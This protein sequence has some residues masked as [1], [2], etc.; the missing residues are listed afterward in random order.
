VLASRALAKETLTLDVNGS[1]VKTALYR[2]YKAA[3]V[4]GQPVKITNTATRRC[5]RWSRFGFADHAGAGCIE[6]LQDRAQL[7]HA[8]RQAGRCLEG[9]TERPLCCGAEDHGSQTG[10]RSHHGIG[11]S[12]GRPRDR[13]SHLVSSG[14]TGTLD[15]IEDG[16]EPENTEFRDDALRRPSIAPATT[17]VFTVAMW[18]ARIARQICAARRP[19]SGHVQSLSLWPHRHRLGRGACENSASGNKRNSSCGLD[20]RP[21]TLLLPPTRKS[22]MAGQARP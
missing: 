6:R 21:S 4:A 17:S 12:P 22:W 5:R 13:Q 9:E 3:E 19:M 15:W 14:D 18:C 7:F 8:R 20:P 1:P 10:I 16:E 11:L 2:S